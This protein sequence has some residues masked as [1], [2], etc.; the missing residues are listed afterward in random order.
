MLYK[1][2]AGRIID[3]I[4]P[5][6]FPDHK[7]MVENKELIPVIQVEVGTKP[8]KAPV[9]KE[10]EVILEAV[11]VPKKEKLVEGAEDINAVRKEYEAKLGKRPFNGWTIK[12]LR[13][14][15]QD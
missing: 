14:K 9:V 10:K 4:N 6:M 1:N 3:G 5:D 11:A 8:T 15:L 7:R 13:E 12:Q 2:R